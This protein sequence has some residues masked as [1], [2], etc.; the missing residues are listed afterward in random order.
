MAED[1][2][3]KCRLQ[4]MIVSD[5][6]PALMNAIQNLR[7]R[8]T[9]AELLKEGLRCLAKREGLLTIANSE[10]ATA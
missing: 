5:R 8:Y 7:K 9:D 4:V 10:E 3:K 1:V 2:T 6:E